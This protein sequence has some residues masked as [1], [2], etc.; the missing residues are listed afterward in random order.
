MMRAFFSIFFMLTFWSC[1]S[2]GTEFPVQ[3]RLFA[4]ATSADPA[5]LNSEL[6]AQG[7]QEFSSITKYGAE[8]T[9]SL[10]H[11]LDFGFNYTKRYT[12]KG[13]ADTSSNSTNQVLI[14]QD[15]VM[16]IARVPIFKS[17]LLRFD[18]FAGVGGSNTTLT[19]KT[20]SQDGE[21]TRRESNDWFASMCSSYG[22]SVAIG[23][24]K[25]YFVIEGGVDS[26]KVDSFKRTG[27]IN[28]NIQTADLS[29][30]YVSIGLLFD[31]LPAK[32]K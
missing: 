4:G 9:Y 16:L 2:F 28:D 6:K 1:A 12:S 17:D 19:L 26:N 21:L 25:I 22:A 23:Y 31:G 3:A 29:G 30:G 14:N 24:K 10:A 11:F 5:N 7:L 18:A 13:D 32:S 20:A 15:S 8:A 27:N